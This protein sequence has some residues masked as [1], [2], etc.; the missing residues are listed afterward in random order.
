M[1]GN[2]RRRRREFV[3]RASGRRARQELL[4]AG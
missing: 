2:Q 3:I 4:Y 1:S